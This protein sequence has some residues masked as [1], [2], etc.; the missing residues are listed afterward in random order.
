MKAHTLSPQNEFV[1]TAATF[2]SEVGSDLQINATAHDTIADFD[3]FDALWFRLCEG[4]GLP[5][6][7]DHALLLPEPTVPPPDA[8]LSLHR[9]HAEPWKTDAKKQKCEIQLFM[10]TYNVQSLGRNSQHKD[11]DPDTLFLGKTKYIAEQIVRNNI[12]IAAL[13]ECR[14][15]VSSVF[16]SDGIIRYTSAGDAGSHGTEIWI[17]RTVPIATYGK[18]KIFPSKEAVVVIHADPRR[19]V[20]RLKLPDRYIVCTSLHAPQSG[21]PEHERE[22]WWHHTKQILAPFCHK[23]LMIIGG[24]TSTRGYLERSCLGWETWFVRIATRTQSCFTTSLNIS[25][26]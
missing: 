21:A 19:L 20:I 8:E 26:C 24:E 2:L 25:T 14:C 7:V 4:Q 17:N 5:D 1:D 12:H 16:Q 9:L 3:N 11:L 10:A 18:T 22:Q 13:Q 23:D 6:V 15:N